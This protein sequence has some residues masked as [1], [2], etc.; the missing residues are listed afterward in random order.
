MQPGQPMPAG[1]SGFNP[2]ALQQ[3]AARQRAAVM[4]QPVQPVAPD[5]NAGFDNPAVSQMLRAPQP[6]PAP[7][8]FAPMGQPPRP[9][10]P[11]QPGLAAPRAFEGGLGGPMKGGKGAK[12]PGATV[13]QVAGA[14]GMR[15]APPAFR[16]SVMPQNRQVM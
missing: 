12:A 6:A 7:G 16:P 13:G 8:G 2:A 11:A 15:G 9:M 10:A 4:P 5:Q 1:Q 14:K 3:Q